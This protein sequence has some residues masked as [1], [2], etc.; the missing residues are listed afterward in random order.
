MSISSEFKPDSK[1][2]VL[3]EIPFYRK[4]LTHQSLIFD[5]EFYFEGSLSAFVLMLFRYSCALCIHMLNYLFYSSCKSYLDL[6]KVFFPLH[7]NTLHIIDYYIHRYCTYFPS[8]NLTHLV[9]L[10]DSTTIM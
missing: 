9:K 8:L 5:Y 6:F 3:T 2:L 1:D 10:H 4:K 7:S